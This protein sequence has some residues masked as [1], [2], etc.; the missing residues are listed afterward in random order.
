METATA[1]VMAIG[2]ITTDG[3]YNQG[4]QYGY[5]YYYYPQPYVQYAPPPPVY[6]QPPPPAHYYPPP[7]FSVTVPIRID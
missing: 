2:G 7:L 6:Y 1:M 3:Y 5:G 4:Y